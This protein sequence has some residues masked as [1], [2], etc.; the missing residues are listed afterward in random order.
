MKS[1]EEPPERSIEQ[2][3]GQ[4]IRKLRKAKGA[5]LAQLGEATGL[6]KALLSKIEN[7][8]VSSPVSTLALIADALQ[9][10][11]GFFLDDEIGGE[12]QKCVLVR[13][14]QRIQL[15]KGTEQFGLYYEM[16]AHQKP[17]KIMTPSILIVEQRRPAPVLFTHPGE[18]LLFVL[19]GKMEFTYG[20]DK[21]VMEAGDCVYFDAEV[22]HG[23]RNIAEAPVRGPMVISVR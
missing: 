12:T 13:R 1:L 17:N 8:K 3:I 5:N 11:L 19:E 15:S 18:E 23:G 4:R 10:K 14:D 2:R 20:N 22:P 21:Y 6:S 9:V 16:L 7:G